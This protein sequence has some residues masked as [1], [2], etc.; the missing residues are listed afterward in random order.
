MNRLLL[1]FAFSFSFLSSHFHTRNLL[2]KKVHKKKRIYL[3][4]EIIY[5]RLKNGT[6]YYGRIARLMND[7]IFLTG[8]PIPRIAVKEVLTPQDKSRKYQ[9]S[10]K[11]ILLATAGA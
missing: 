1:L 8:R 7:T 9:I 3:E 4:G 10:T 11:D 6:V 2:V 5:L